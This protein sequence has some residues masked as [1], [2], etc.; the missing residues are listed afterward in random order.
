[1]RGF[2]IFC[3]ITGAQMAVTGPAF[4]QQS[5]NIPL[6]ATVAQNCTITVTP[7]A[8]AS[9][10][11]LSEGARRVLVANLL[12]NC[13]KKAGYRLTV[14]SDNCSAGTPGAKLVGATPSPDQLSY[15]VEFNNPTT[16]GSQAA[17]TGLLSTQCT[18]DAYILARDVSGEKVKDETSDIYVNYAGD[19]GLAADSY[20]DVVRITMTVN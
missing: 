6:A 12:Q 10:L 14:D 20:S 16:G 13:N 19:S 9:N 8:A 15:S 7:T 17:V 5:G 18:G 3:W 2:L 4:A 11:D 1:M